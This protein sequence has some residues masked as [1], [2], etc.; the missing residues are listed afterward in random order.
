MKSLQQIINR[1]QGRGFR[2]KHKIVEGRFVYIRK[3]W[4]YM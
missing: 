4:R 1:Y 2:I 3:L